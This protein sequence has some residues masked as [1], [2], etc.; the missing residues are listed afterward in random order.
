MIQGSLP[1]DH[2]SPHFSWIRLTKIDGSNG[3]AADKY[4]FVLNMYKR[5]LIRNWGKLCQ[6]IVEEQI[7]ESASWIDYLVQLIRL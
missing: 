4:R 1:A 3:F 2:E 7:Q 5:E 6:L